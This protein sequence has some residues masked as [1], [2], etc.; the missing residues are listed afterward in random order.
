MRVITIDMETAWSS[1]D[2]YTL[3]KMGPIEYIRDPRFFVQCVGFRINRG[4]TQCVSYKDGMDRRVLEALKL[5]EP[6]TITVGHNING[7]DALILSE[8]YGIKPYMIVDTIS[9]MNWLGLSR[10][11]SCS[12]KTLTA[13]L[14]HGIKQAGTVVSDGKRTIE[15]FTPEEWEFFMQYCKDDVTQCSE[16]FT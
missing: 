5:D 15:E 7:F 16:N 11:M 13:A 9:L 1:K 3:T 10:I 8:H 14:D 4:K 2:K 12:H 6:G